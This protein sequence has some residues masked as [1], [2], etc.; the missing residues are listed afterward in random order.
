MESHQTPNPRKLSKPKPKQDFLSGIDF[1]LNT[2]QKSNSLPSF[3]TPNTKPPK[4]ATINNITPPPSEKSVRERKEEDKEPSSHDNNINNEIT[5]VEYLQ[6]K[7][8][9]QNLEMKKMQKKTSDLEDASIA[10]MNESESPSL[11]PIQRK[12]I[13]IEQTE[14]LYEIAQLEERMEAQQQIIEKM[15]KAKDSAF[16]K[17]ADLR[18]DIQQFQNDVTR[19]QETNEHF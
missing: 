6:R 19:D 7:I 2:K 15:T 4:T 17:I 11:T 8:K 14:F 9:I 18:N 3:L 1:T 16:L 10:S 5:E 12:E 13:Y